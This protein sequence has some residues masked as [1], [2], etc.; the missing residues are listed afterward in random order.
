MGYL[1]GV[2]STQPLTL[3][4]LLLLTGTYGAWLVIYHIGLRRFEGRPHPW[5]LLALFCLACASQF[6]PL[7]GTNPSWLPL[8]PVITTAYMTAIK[9]RSLSLLAAGA[10]CLSSYLAVRLIVPDWDVSSQVGLLLSFLSIY[11]YA[12][13]IRELALAHL[14]KDASNARL[15]AANSRLQEY[16]AQMGVT[17]FFRVKHTLRTLAPEQMPSGLR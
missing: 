1:S 16:S 15:A 2:L 7:P 5:W 12:V 10:L 11:G 8:L 6:I 4:S 13:I 3:V 9:P 17:I 14:A